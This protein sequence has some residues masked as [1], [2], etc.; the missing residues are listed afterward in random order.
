MTRDRDLEQTLERWLADGPARMPDHVFDA[1][2][3]RVDRTPQRRLAGLVTRYLNMPLNIR[4]T[5]VAATVVIAIAAVGAWALAGPNRS[6]VGG[7]PAAS[8]SLPASPSP[9]TSPAASVS[10]IADGTYALAPMKVADLTA[11]INADS[12]LSAAEKKF[13]IETAFAMKGGKTF[14]VSLDLNRGRLVEHQAVDG[15]VNVG[16]EGTYTIPDDQTLIVQ[17]RCSCPPTTFRL[18]VTGNSFTLQIVNPPTK[19]ADALPGR[20]LF[21]SGPFTRQP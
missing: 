13:L 16:T 2:I 21:E 18:A 19:E 4:F 3:D 6:D 15:V 12:K 9:S 14:V 20:V 5:A 17:E 10:P 7:G 8:A 1:L 11:M